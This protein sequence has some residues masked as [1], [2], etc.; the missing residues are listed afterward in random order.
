MHVNLAV[1]YI[2][3]IWEAVNNF[4]LKDSPA[5]TFPGSKS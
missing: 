4:A 5:P 3:N 2:G 1:T